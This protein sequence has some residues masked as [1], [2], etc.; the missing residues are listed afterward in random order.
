MPFWS[1]AV[2]NRKRTFFTDARGNVGIIFAFALLPIILAVGS[3]LDYGRYNAARARIQ[4]ALDATGLMLAHQVDTMSQDEIDELAAQVF[5]EN[6]REGAGITIKQLKTVA[7]ADKINLA[8]K[9]DVETYIMHLA[10]VEFLPANV[11]S[12]IVRS[13][14]SFEVVLVLDNTGSMDGSKIEALKDAAET[15]V[16]NLFGE[17]TVH[18]LL[19]M[20]LVPFSH[21]VNVGTAYANASW[22][23]TDG[24]NPLHYDNFDETAM[25][26][27]N[28]TRF[29]LY[30]RIRNV[31]WGGCVEARAY[32][33]D[34]RDTEASSANPETLFVPYFAP[35]EPDRVCTSYRRDGRCRRYEGEYVN[36]YLD[37]DIDES[38]PDVVRQENISKYKNNVTADDRHLSRDLGFAGPNFGC[39]A[40]PITP[41]TNRKSTVT[42]ALDD[43]KA[44]GYTN[45]AEGLI[46]GLRVVSPAEPFSE[47]KPYATVNHHKVIILLTDG[48]NTGP[49][50]GS[51]SSGENNS[52]FGAWG[53]AKSG[54]LI[55]TTRSSTYKAEMDNRTEEACDAVKDERIDL[56]TITFG[57][58]SESTKTL[59]RNCA[60]QSDM[61]Y[62][63]PSTSTLD[64][65]FK[66]IA[67]RI[68]KLRIAK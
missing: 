60:T 6:F 59:M 34:I 4:T 30:D 62:D 8:A 40:N 50:V 14:D 52:Y 44:A 26:N 13:E 65:V 23:D 3:A 21:A 20:A 41:L 58:P 1:N 33:L 56:F 25:K 32:P 53:F 29:D 64:A 63:S 5:R 35:D 24:L 16:D 45:I 39:T 55:D 57:D 15:L 10:G 66:E 11:D 18:P 61:Y 19:D 43:M 48:D 51:S 68:S 28:L 7:S 49:G 36:S 9:A 46:W 47:G 17:T 27:Q 54:R 31:N 42:N 22:M 67:T 38:E 2:R 12:E 37:D